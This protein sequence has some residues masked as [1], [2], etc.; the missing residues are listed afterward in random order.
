MGCKLKPVHVNLASFWFQ[1]FKLFEILSYQWQ[2]A[3]RMFTR[4][5][6]T[7]FLGKNMS[8]CIF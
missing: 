7:T 3:K 6:F 8:T 5:G 2:A 1:I 4:G